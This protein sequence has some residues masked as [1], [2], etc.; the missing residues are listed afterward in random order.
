MLSS[1]RIFSSLACAAVVSLLFAACDLFDKKSDACDMPVSRVSFTSYDTT[2]SAA[3]RFIV[4]SIYAT[5]GDTVDVSSQITGPDSKGAYSFVYSGSIEGF[6]E[7]E[8]YRD[9][10][11]KARFNVP[12]FPVADTACAAPTDHRKYSIVWTGVPSHEGFTDV[13]TLDDSTAVAP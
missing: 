4:D 12:V 8:L 10:T 3:T 5:L 7:V 1:A 6:L 2:R 11:A 13:Q 9:S